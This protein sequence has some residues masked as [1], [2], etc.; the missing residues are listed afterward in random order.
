MRTTFAFCAALLTSGCASAGYWLVPV[1]PGSPAASAP[2]NSAIQV[3]EGVSVTV[4]PGKSASSAEPGETLFGVRV[5][6]AGARPARLE[7]P[8]AWLSDAEDRD[9]GPMTLSA[10]SAAVVEAGQ[11]WEGVARFPMI[12]GQS[13]AV[14]LTVAVGRDTGPVRYFFRYRV[15]HRTLEPRSPVAEEL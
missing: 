7:E 15:I 13:D 4:W 2:A 9:A 10:S 3:R 1:H 6:N 8:F 12:R 14:V 5:E 11:T